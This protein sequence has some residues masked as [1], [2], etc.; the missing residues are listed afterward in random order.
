MINQSSASESNLL[1]NQL[2]NNININNHQ[3]IR[4]VVLFD[5]TS[6]QDSE[7]DNENK[8]EQNVLFEANHILN[9][10]PW[11]KSGPVINDNY[12][13]SFKMGRKVSSEMHLNRI[14][15]QHYD[16]RLTQ[17]VKKT[18]LKNSTSECNTSK[19][20]SN[21]SIASINKTAFYYESNV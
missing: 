7:S 4:K 16:S 2:N 21:K 12:H 1:I 19:T 15:S 17:S 8:D 13:N 9:D 18:I 6:T 10:K 20:T 14:R 3:S 11:G 5:I